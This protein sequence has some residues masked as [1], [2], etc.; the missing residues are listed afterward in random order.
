MIAEAAIVRVLLDSHN[1][2]GIV[3]VSLYAW[4]NVL[5]ELSVSA[6]LLS[7]LC[8]TD[9]AFI[10]EQRI[11]VRLEVVIIPLEGLFR[12]PDLC[13]EDFGLFVLHNTR[14]PSGNTLAAAAV[15]VNLH[16]EEVAVLHCLLRQVDFPVAGTRNL[17]EAIRF[18][19]LPA[20]EI[21]NQEDSG[22]IWC[23]L[24]ENPTIISL[25]KTKIEVTRSKF[26]KRTFAVLC[27]LV[28]LPDCM[29]MT[30][31]NCA[32]EWFK[33]RI[34]CHQT[35]VFNF[36]HTILCCKIHETAGA[37]QHF[38]LSDNFYNLILSI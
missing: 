31:M 12:I 33:P 23:P 11:D 5:F 13:G 16:L 19:F 24:T 15:P 37:L 35:D 29:V 22:S 18:F 2:N 14:C 21:A 27:E 4:Q 36:T 30:T 7:I 17:L 38:L 10:D 6:D 25:V 28:D 20:I 32:L 26:R 8:H 9:M 1:L 3:T 34:I